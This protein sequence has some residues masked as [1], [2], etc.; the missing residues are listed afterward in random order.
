MLQ[1][2]RRINPKNFVWKCKR[3]QILKTILSRR[4]TIE[5]IKI[6]QFKLQG[7]SIVTKTAWYRYKGIY[8]D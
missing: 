6:I 1:R 8:L 2:T 4:N 3:P 7:I 5:V